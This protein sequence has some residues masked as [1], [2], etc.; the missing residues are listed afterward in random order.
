MKLSCSL[1]VVAGVCIFAQSSQAG[2]NRWDA[3]AAIDSQLDGATGPSG[4]AKPS[5]GNAVARSE[6]NVSQYRLIA[7]Q[8][9][10]PAPPSSGGGA[11]PGASIGTPQTLF[12]LATD[13][14]IPAG[15]E[16]RWSAALTDSESFRKGIGTLLARW[17]SPCDP[18]VPVA[19]LPAIAKFISAGQLASAPSWRF[20]VSPVPLSIQD[21]RRQ[22][23]K[24]N[25]QAASSAFEIRFTIEVDKLG[26]NE[27][28]L[29]DVKAQLAHMGDNNVEF[30]KAIATLKEFVGNSKNAPTYPGGV[31]MLEN[32][33]Q[34]PK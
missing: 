6:T 31:F 2:R 9:A 12:I 30:Y 29:K 4:N 33:F 10:Q 27:T 22:K 7:M 8:P 17:K 23:A 11:S 13:L 18:P 19:G 1:L 24:P 26:L 16:S 14:D 5:T 3:I 32:A 21:A 34:L 25:A 28:Q 20:S 15:T